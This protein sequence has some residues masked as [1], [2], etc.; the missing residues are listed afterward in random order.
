MK[1]TSK[2]LA[3]ATVAAAIASVI[4]LALA[5]AGAAATG[6][7]ITWIYQSPI[8][9]GHHLNATSAPSATTTFA[10]GDYGTILYWNGTTMVEQSSGTTSD[11]Y[12]VWALSA[13]RAW[14]VGASGTIRY[15]N[16]TTWSMQT[17]PT[18]YNLLAVWGLSAS[19]IWAVG[20]EDGFNNP[21]IVHYDGTS[22]TDQTP[23]GMTT[24]GFSDVHALN[25]THVWAVGGMDGATWFFDG[26]NWN[27]INDG[28][29]FSLYQVSAGN[30]NVVYGIAWDGTVVRSADGGVTYSSVLSSVDWPLA[31]HAVSATNVFVV[32]TG[33]TIRTFNGTTWTT[34]TS[35]TT[36]DL[37]DVDAYSATGIFTVGDQT[38]LS[39]TG[40]TWTTRKGMIPSAL[41]G[42]SSYDGTNVWAVGANTS[43]YG[44]IYY[45]G[46]GGGVWRAQSSGTTATYRGVV[47][48]D[49]N[50]VWTCGA[51][52]VV[53]YFN[54]TSWAA[55]SSGTTR[56]LYGITA[57]DSTHVWACGSRIIQF[58]NGS[59][60]SNTY[61]NNSLTFNG[62]SAADS[63]HVWA[64]GN[65]GV[66]RFWNG[67]SW[68]TQSTGITQNLTDVWA[69]DATHVWAVGAGGRI[70]FFNGTAWA[71]Q[72]SPV[73]VN[74]MGVSGA[75]ANHV[76]AAGAN[77]T[78]LYFDGSTWIQFEDPAPTTVTLNDVC[79][80]D[81]NNAWAVGTA[82]TVLFADPPYIKEC[83][84]NWGAPGD[85]VDVEITGAFTHFQTMAPTLS[86]GDG[87][88]VVPGTVNVVDNT[89]VQAR[90]QVDGGAQLGP[91]EVNAVSAVEVPVPL[92]GGFN[93]GDAPTVT[94]AAPSAGARGWTG[95]VAV[96]GSRTHFSDASSVS[97][98]AGVT[99]NEVRGDS[100]D[101]LV[102]NIS[103][104]QGAAPGSRSVSVVTGPETPQ[105]LA[106]GFTIPA[107][108]SV[109]SVSPAV[110]PP[111][112]PVTI[113]GSGFGAVQKE[114]GGPA[115][116]VSFGGMSASCTSW[117]DS[118]I[119]CAV[120]EGAVTG[121]VT[122]A[123]RNGIS[124]ADKVFTIA[125]SRWYLAEG[126][127]A[128][129]FNTDIAVM[130]PNSQSVTVRM[131]YLTNDG[132][133][134]RPD[135]KMAPMSRTTINPVN[136]GSL[137]SADF[138]TQVECLEGLS[139]AADRT[140]FWKGPG[141]AAAEGHS[142]IGVTG[143]ANTWYLPEGST[144]WGFECWLLIMNPS[145]ADADC[146]VTY[147]I[148]G[149]GPVTVHKQVPARSR[150]SFNVADDIGAA[151]ASI[152]VSSGVG[153]IAERAMYRNNRREG[154][155][156]IGV[157]APSND[158][159]LAE[160]STAWG[161]STYVLVQNPNPEPAQVT[162]TYMTP[163]GAAQQP[164]FT[165]QANSRKTIRVS[166][167]AP[168]MDMST[169]VHGSL[170]IVAERSMYW[171]S[172]KGEACHD[173]IGVAAP[174]PAFYLADGR[175]GY[176]FE[177]YFET[178]TLVQNPNDVPVDITIEY[179]TYDGLQNQVVTDTIPAN[180]RRSYD[181]GDKIKDNFA[182]IVV[183]SHTVGRNLIAE[184]AMYW[185]SRAAG[186]CTVGA[187]F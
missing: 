138:S 3:G 7:D 118:E 88:S 157:T 28:V 126:S 152:M 131:T 57:S 130:N 31:I 101:R 84:P 98:G 149:Q 23:A 55:Q 156:S 49:A 129:G 119:T 67:S 141:A 148:E 185:D 52:G 21:V 167:A 177:R 155:D 135:I 29:D 142:S 184:R 153:V 94:G 83:R 134:S 9:S 169:N 172:G 103:V 108:P 36:V 34:R 35:G 110:G 16:G 8:P 140:M 75:D 4:V 5:G 25:A 60:W 82:G 10:V 63:T 85:T 123:G 173:S 27:M 92:A 99:V 95:D 105:P 147:M 44:N 128:W 161:F 68:S 179:L 79:T 162:V 104:S 122:V 96:T 78:I 58:Y 30:A 53:R 100:G 66:V 102:A 114:G 62:I 112:T 115:S 54:G 90:V 76:W 166:D 72:G 93:V 109:A 125:Q 1:R 182:G 15:Y 33:G 13:T 61:T 69:L 121:P 77:G 24:G 117:A 18:G 87:V 50:H 89:H 71:S 160:G 43:S 139:I 133:V 73:T 127:T 59:T 159:Y 120:P 154:H 175:S 151:D 51:S 65:S 145:A 2:R 168:G 26:T 20:G 113:R 187:H 91:R 70:M 143:P 12:G 17:S 97:F 132:P 183:Q 150:A 171:D 170:P 144:A 181:M 86:F 107:P 136:D 64:V 176:G 22:W 80:F 6:P 164:A 48:V 47:A 180:S 37:D 74:L 137:A 39:S 45:S 124:N 146:A 163:S 32:G 11:L 106:G 178:W 111:G 81:R 46:D 19:N 116:T 41:Y 186:S 158:F 174:H 14:A 42:A 165:L 56:A 38:L 40:T